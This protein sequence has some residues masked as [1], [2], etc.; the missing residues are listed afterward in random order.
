MIHVAVVLVVVVDDNFGCGFWFYGRWIS[1]WLL[2]VA[3]RSG[4][5]TVV[6]WNSIPWSR[7]NLASAKISMVS[8][9]R[10]SSPKYVYLIPP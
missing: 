6:H 7:T 10:E 3:A 2:G 9:G 1:E 5:A 4:W 8:F